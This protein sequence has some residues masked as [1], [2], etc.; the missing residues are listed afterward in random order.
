MTTAAR[1]EHGMTGMAVTET[2]DEF[3]AAVPT[4]PHRVVLVFRR[5]HGGRL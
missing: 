3:I 1:T 2:I 4:G 5:E